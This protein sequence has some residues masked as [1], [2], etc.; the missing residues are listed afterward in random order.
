MGRKMPQLQAASS[1]PM[2]TAAFFHNPA[3]LGCKNAPLVYK[4]AGLIYY[5]PGIAAAIDKFGNLLLN[6]DEENDHK[7]DVRDCNLA[8]TD[9]GSTDGL[10][11]FTER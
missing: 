3:N 2:A 5:F 7:Y 6:D 1:K 11:A 8:C 9:L 10:T 4:N